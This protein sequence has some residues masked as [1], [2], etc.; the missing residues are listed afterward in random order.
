MIVLILSLE[1]LKVRNRR[2]EVARDEF[3]GKVVL[4]LSIREGSHSWTH[5]VDLHAADACVRGGCHRCDIAA[6]DV[7]IIS[8]RF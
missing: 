2:L 7:S 1:L 4:T 3:D 6:C 8:R 5:S